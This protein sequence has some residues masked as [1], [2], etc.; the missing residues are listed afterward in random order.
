[1][2]MGDEGAGLLW[3]PHFAMREGGQVNLVKCFRNWK[4]KG[5]ETMPPHDIN[6]GCGWKGRLSAWLRF[7]PA[8]ILVLTVAWGVLVLRRLSYLPV[9][10]LISPD[11]PGYLE[12]S[13]I[14]PHGYSLFLELYRFVV[15]DLSYLP[16]TQWVMLAIGCLLLSLAVGWR[17]NNIVGAGVVFICSCYFGFRP[18]ASFDSVGSDAIYEALIV[19]AAACIV[20]YFSLSRLWLLAVSSALL[21]MALISR[22]VGYA[23][24]PVFA[25]CV[26]MSCWSRHSGW[27]SV[28]LA[29]TLPVL[30]WC[31]I[32]AGSNLLRHGHFRVG[33]YGG[34]SLLG[35][36]LV[37]AQPLPDNSSFK[38]ANWVAEEVRP[39]QK[40]LAQ[41]QDPILKALVVRQY[42]ERLRWSV[43]LP[44]FDRRLPGWRE[45]SDY[46]QSRLA[47]SLATEYIRNDLWG[48]GELIALDYM[49]L[50][51]V[52]RVLTKNE[53]EFFERSYR[54]L[55]P[56]PFLADFE[57]THRPLVGYFQVVPFASPLMLV[58]AVRAVNLGFLLSS[59]ALIFMLLGR[60]SRRKLLDQG[61]DAIFLI[62][63]VHASYLATAL[64]EAG[65][66]RYTSPT[67]PIMVAA[68]VRVTQ[69]AAQIRIARYRQPLTLRN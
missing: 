13:E 65:L 16:H 22:T 47:G 6:D 12:A 63:S 7:G 17:V 29:A 18:S 31:A 3:C 43:F 8:Q 46:E 10:P 14:R 67:W 5:D 37:L 9:Q 68:I 21:G 49:S 19:S 15:G 39:T 44:R 61:V 40:A 57:A 24:L 58:L 2:W 4:T 26:G 62:G 50:W 54:A 64:V 36:G 1:M 20:W 35:K 66:E 53:R 27:R 30:I 33:S 28:I 45:A 55:G 32:G 38:S 48:Y 56:L 69:L 60:A 59:L 23:I 25:I 42:Y 52:P 34:M 11:S 41:I 51:A